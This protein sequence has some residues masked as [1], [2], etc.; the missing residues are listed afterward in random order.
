MAALRGR[1][2][3]P[4]DAKQSPQTIVNYLLEEAHEVAAAVE[5]GKADHIREELGDLLFEIVFMTQFFVEK[6]LFDLDGVAEEAAQKMIRRHPHVFATASAHTADQVKVQWKQIKDREN[7]FQDKP[8]GLLDSVPKT[9]PALARAHRLSARAAEAGFDWDDRNGVWD[10][11]GEETAEVNRARHEGGEKLLDELGDL[12]F[13]I[14]NLTRHLGQNAEAVLRRTND[15][16]ARRF[17]AIEDELRNK[18]RTLADSD[19]AEMNRIWDKIK[20][21]GG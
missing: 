8:A 4:W 10:K 21:E 7:G 6:G 9:L 20:A 5:E 1:I 19:P 11:L 15:K 18:G 16:F 17:A 3:C 2:G 13:T 12:L 14:A